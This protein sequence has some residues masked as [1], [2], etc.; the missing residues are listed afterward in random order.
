[1]RHRD[2]DRPHRLLLPNG[3][4]AN[5]TEPRELPEHYGFDTLVLLPRDP[6]ACLA[7]WEISPRTRERLVSESGEDFPARS[8]LVLKVRRSG[9]AP[10][11]LDVSGP[12]RAW[13]F[14][15]GCPGATIAAE[16]GL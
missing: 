3:R 11:R 13:V 5:L 6:S 8:R 7:F 2:Q 14:D 4:G 10:L 16:L 1:M 9:Q 12:T 15:P